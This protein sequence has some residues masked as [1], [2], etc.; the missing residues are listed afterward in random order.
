VADGNAASE[1]A[2]QTQTG[3][4]RRRVEAKKGQPSASEWAE[5]WGLNQRDGMRTEDKGT[6]LHTVCRINR[7]E[8]VHRRQGVKGD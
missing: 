7:A 5:S 6:G 3:P 1:D 4:G 2:W 8:M